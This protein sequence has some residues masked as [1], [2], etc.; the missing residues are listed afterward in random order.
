MDCEESLYEMVVFTVFCSLVEAV[1]D[2]T[3][4]LL[5]VML[6]AVARYESKTYFVGSSCMLFTVLP[7]IMERIMK[8]EATPRP[9]TAAIAIIAII[10]FFLLFLA[11]TSDI[12]YS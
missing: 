10:S 2:F 11:T 8:N 5:A 7:L 6:S 4:A 1:A 12:V 3:T 9:I